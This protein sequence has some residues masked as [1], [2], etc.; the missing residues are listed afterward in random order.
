MYELVVP[1]SRADVIVRTPAVDKAN[2]VT[3]LPKVYVMDGKSVVASNVI[4]ESVVACPSD[5]EMAPEPSFP[6]IVGV[7]QPEMAASAEKNEFQFRESLTSPSK[8]VKIHGKE[9]C[10]LFIDIFKIILKA[11]LALKLGR[12]K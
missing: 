9:K 2:G 6:V 8:Y 11:I 10:T 4:I 5:T 3:A 12:Q 7:V 1:A